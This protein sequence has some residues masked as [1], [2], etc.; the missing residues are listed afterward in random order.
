M[1]TVSRELGIS[2]P[3]LESH[4]RA[5]E[6]T[7]ALTLVRPF[8]G[9]GQKEVVKMPK[10]YG[11]DTGFV[12]FCRG[13]DPLR[14]DDFGSLW[15]HVVLEYFLAHE[16]QPLYWRDAS[17]RE[18]DFVIPRGRGSVDAVECK[19]NPNQFDP[20]SMKVLRRYYPRGT[21]YV[22]CPISVQGYQKNISGLDIYVCHPAGWLEHKSKRK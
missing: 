17:G 7:H 8:H 22:I 4:V 14:P 15:E 2:R 11:L 6:A 1:V 20:S 21:N 13:W 3:T 16:E 9:G 5:L 18:V 19:W 12:S 10:A